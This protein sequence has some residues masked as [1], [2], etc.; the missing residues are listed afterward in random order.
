VPR[1][2]LLLSVVGFTFFSLFGYAQDSELDEKTLKALKNVLKLEI[3]VRLVKQQDEVV[4][5]TSGSRYTIPGRAV[6]IKIEGNN[7]KLY[8][9]FT[10]HYDRN[11]NLMILVQGQLFISDPENKS[12]RYF[13][14][15]KTILVKPGEKIVFFPLG[16]QPGSNLETASNI[17][18]DIQI[19]P[20]G[21]DQKEISK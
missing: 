6:N 14:Y 17:E 3:E 5:N 19:I 9:S 16:K 18:I 8:G 1:K 15:I 11:S 21:S 7:L 2:S 10:P 12:F 4:W 20:Y 13:T